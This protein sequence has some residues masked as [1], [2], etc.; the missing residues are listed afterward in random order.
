MLRFALRSVD[1]DEDDLPTTNELETDGINPTAYDRPGT[2]RS[3]PTYESQ[4][5]LAQSA[6]LPAGYGQGQFGESSF[7]KPAVGMLDDD[8]EMIASQRRVN[9]IIAGNSGRPSERIK[10]AWKELKDR[11]WGKPKVLEG[12]RMIHINDYSL[13]ESSKFSNNYVSTSKYNL[14][15]FV[16]KFF[17]GPSFFLS[18]VEFY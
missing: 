15:T 4:A 3:R 13:N 7:A 6:Q 18:V 9:K 14:I 10:G 17:T 16:P 1:S 12:E 8:E 2:G 5:P 11:V